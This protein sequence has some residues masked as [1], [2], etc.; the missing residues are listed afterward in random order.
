MSKQITREYIWMEAARMNNCDEPA[1]NEAGA[2]LLASLV[3]GARNK[4]IAEF[5][6]IPVHRVRKRSRN[7]RRNNIWQGVKVAAD[8]WFKKPDGG[9]SF[10]MDSLVADGLMECKSA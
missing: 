5:L 9:T 4:A 2:I 7:L 3:V 1:K 10:I 8:A 6:D